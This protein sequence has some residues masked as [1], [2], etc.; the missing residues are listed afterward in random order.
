MSEI[1]VN[2][3]LPDIV[4]WKFR[5]S[6]K[7]MEQV[8]IDYASRIKVNVEPVELKDESKATH[9][10]NGEEYFCDLESLTVYRKEIAGNWVKTPLSVQSVYFDKQFVSTNVYK[11][12]FIQPLKNT[13]DE[14]DHNWIVFNSR[15]IGVGRFI[16]FT[17]A[18]DCYINEH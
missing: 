18:V 4:V 3:K 2:L 8:L 6:N 16:N 13:I 1:D 7:T 9:I 17:D 12:N 10:K 11:T 15:W 14:H 5:R